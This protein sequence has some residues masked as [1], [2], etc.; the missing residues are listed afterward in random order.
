MRAEAGTRVIV[1][2]AAAL[3]GC[4]G[5]ARVFEPAVEGAPSTPS[6][7]N[8]ARP[9]F[10]GVFLGDD[11]STPER[12]QA[13][14]DDYTRMAGRR[15]ALVKT[16]HDL[17]ADLSATGWAGRVLAQVADAGAT[18]FVALDLEWPNRPAGS[19]LDLI[20]SG[21]ADAQLARAARSIA[22][23]GGIVLVEP[24]WEMNGNWNYSWQGTANGSD[25]SAPARYAR[26]WRHVVNVFRANGASNVRWVFNP[27]VGNAVSSASTGA[28]HWNWYANYYPGDAYVDYVG[29]HGYNGP[30][31]WGHGYKQFSDVFFGADAD[32]ILTD[33]STRYPDKPII[34]GEMAT[35]A[36][37]DKAAW[38]TS[39][40]RQMRSNPSIVGAIWFDMKKEA[41]WRIAS[42]AASAAAYRAAMSEYS[43]DAVY[44]DIVA[45]NAVMLAGR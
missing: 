40:Y 9:F 16:F 44:A 39:A 42:T 23:L 41:D 28:Q 35:D 24:A 19:L 5:D 15:P 34:I 27:N 25:A 22:A 30:S 7:R 14:I 3:I 12:V 13:A 31:V 4:G 26:A 10:G 37:G 36:T 43:V 38:I 45:T 8:P 6:S 11:A 2:F 33:M 20:N 21:A 18:N 17:G 29:A 32:N 1:L